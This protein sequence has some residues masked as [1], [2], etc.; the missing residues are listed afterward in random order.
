MSATQQSV[1][2]YGSAM[3]APTSS[4]SSPQPYGTAILMQ[5]QTRNAAPATPTPTNPYGSGSVP[6]TA[7]RPLAPGT[8]YRPVQAGA[9][10]MLG[11]S[12]SQ[13]RGYG[14]NGLPQGSNGAVPQTPMAASPA[15]FTQQ[16]SQSSLGGAQ[17]TP[18]QPSGYS[19]QLLAM[20]QQQ[21]FQQQQQQ[22]SSAPRET[23]QA[24][25]SAPPVPIKAPL[26]VLKLE[27]SFHPIREPNTAWS[28]Q[29]TQGMVGIAIQGT[30]MVFQQA[31]VVAFYA[32]IQQTPPN[33][34]LRLF[35]PLSQQV[36][37]FSNGNENTA[38]LSLV[39][40]IESGEAWQL[41]IVVLP[42]DQEEGEPTDF[43]SMTVSASLSKLA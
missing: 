34:M 11:Y 4:S 27:R 41:Q 23:Q 5:G 18:P 36:V 13:A 1:R 7:Q 29:S 28:V 39:K 40:P 17:Q 24:Q 42:Q 6:A 30:S 16:A 20:R 10:S 15:P 19:Q 35:N 31:G 25:P 33:T 21:I 38:F 12:P 2:P 26:S 9:N 43:P 14:A 37:A 8:P 22:A 3:S 32:S